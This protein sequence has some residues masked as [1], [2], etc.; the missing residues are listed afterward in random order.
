MVWI[1]NKLVCDCSSE[2]ASKG[3]SKEVL[4]SQYRHSVRVS[5]SMHKPVLPE[6]IQ[7]NVS[8]NTFSVSKLVY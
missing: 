6:C 5:H 3:F 1:K 4:D 7:T 8:Y 2:K